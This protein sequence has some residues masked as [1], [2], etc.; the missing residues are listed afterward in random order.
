M[1][2]WS[3]HS[4]RL[5]WIR[6]S[7]LGALLCV[8]G[9]ATSVHAA[10]WV[11]T[12]ETTPAVSNADTVQLWT[13]VN[14]TD[15]TGAVQSAKATD[16]KVAAGGGIYTAGYRDTGSTN[17]DEILAT[18][19]QADGSQ[20]WETVVTG[21][22][23]RNV[24]VRL[25]LD[26]LGNVYLT[27]VHYDSVGAAFILTAK[28]N[29]TGTVVC[30]DL[31]TAGVPEGIL[32]TPSATYVLA[33]VPNGSTRD[34]AVM[35]VNTSTCALSTLYSPTSST[36]DR[37][38]AMAFDS[39]SAP[40]ILYVLGTTDI[41]TSTDRG[42]VRIFKYVLGA[43]PDATWGQVLDA[44]NSNNRD[45][46]V[47]LDVASGDPYVIFDRLDTQ[48]W[49][50]NAQTH[51]IDPATGT[52]LWTSG[53]ASA[54]TPVAIYTGAYARALKVKAGDGVYVAFRTAAANADVVMVKYDLNGGIVW[55]SAAPYDVGNDDDAVA[56]EV[57]PS[58]A[59]PD[60]VYVAVTQGDAVG[61][62][63]HDIAILHYEAGG[64][65]WDAFVVNS[66]NDDRAGA[67]ALGVDGDN[68]TT[69]QVVGGG[70][71]KLPSATA[72]GGAYTI[73]KLGHA[74]PDLTTSVSSVPT[75]AVSDGLMTVQNTVTNELN[76]QL[77][78]LLGVTSPFDV[79]FYF[80]TSPTDINPVPVTASPARQLSSLAS[81]AVDSSA[82]TLVVPP[83]ATLTPG[84]YYLMAKV[85]VANVIFERDET[86]NS[87]VSGS[88]IL[89]VD[90]P[91]LQPTALNGAPANAPAGS[92]LNLTYAVHNTRTQPPAA[93]FTQSF[94]LVPV[95]GG[96]DVPLTGTSTISQ[97]ADLTA[98]ANQGTLSGI[99]VSV[100][101]PAATPA[102]NYELDV[103]VDSTGAIAESIETNNRLTVR[104]S[105]TVD[106]IPDLTVSLTAYDLGAT[107]GAQMSV[108]DSVQTVDASVN[109]SF[110]VS[111]YLSTD[112]TITSGDTLLSNSGT[113]QRTITALNV[114]TPDAATTLVDVPSSVAPGLYYL[115]AIVDS[116]SAIAES[117]EAN[118][119]AVSTTQISVGV[120]AGQP[121]EVPD[122]YMR[123]V[124]SPTSVTRGSAFNVDTVLDNLLQP[125][126]TTPFTVGIYLSPD[127]TITTADYL[128]FQIDYASFSVS[129]D[130]RTTPVTVPGSVT[131]LATWNTA[132]ASFCGVVAG[133]AIQANVN[134]GT[135]KIN[136]SGAISNESFSGDGSVQITVPALGTSF[137]IGLTTAHSQT[138]NGGLTSCH[139]LPGMNYGLAVDTTGG[140]K[141]YE[142]G[143]CTPASCLGGQQLTPVVAG[144]VIR[145]SREQGS[146][147]KYYLNGVL[148][149]T[150]TVSSSGVLYADI[151]LGA[152]S[153]QINSVD[154]I[155]TPIS[156]GTYYLGAIADI[157]GTVAE[158]NENNNTAI[159]TGSGSSAASVVVAVQGADA[160]S[161]GSGGGALLWL[162]G[163]LLA[164]FRLRALRSVGG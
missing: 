99:P 26:G 29:S 25:A 18:R 68:Q 91:D 79:S 47:G 66:A 118:N 76:A 115:G 116:G 7:C 129:S 37:A 82:V 104:P 35:S 92:T 158:L 9:S 94:V 87:W 155:V 58:A 55:Q 100:T 45:Q 19:H 109:Q 157:N 39:P 28:L 135:W 98:L 154:F 152:G 144:D 137:A 8:L 56:I 80:A 93:A 49:T 61:S 71:S 72:G 140:L 48:N 32:S 50:F 133:N 88:T 102:G 12:P 164:A 44:A 149:Y 126:V 6:K 2:D 46:A 123:S 22:T 81:G 127:S 67:I 130:A 96:A 147:I 16:V 138:C 5:G 85:D 151:S 52:S 121:G 106:P 163:P 120:A 59:A 33:T 159:N 60:E 21:G 119:T 54:A 95:G 84:S 63:G 77:G 141:V 108:S 57:D 11:L 3:A 145:V 4:I 146:T 114:G 101:I 139:G 86:N 74:M 162:L 64:V 143:N 34:I 69:V 36:D 13:L 160:N 15:A 42:Y 30:S 31:T 112:T 62:T 40:T 23:S 41:S 142:S 73:V 65:L 111:Y 136:G 113:A 148:K 122:L 97:S 1:R 107:I 131:S 24:P 90:P 17:G 10:Q 38:V 128:V 89:I 83:V 134:C 78:E 70:D 43:G 161:G 105:I 103:V 132:D 125:T 117:N 53:V 150:S 153:G 20:L 124:S 156:P 110:D 75:S 51:R 27:A 14:Q